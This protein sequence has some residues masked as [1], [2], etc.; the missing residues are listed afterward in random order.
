MKGVIPMCL[1]KLVIDKFG[2][3]KWKDIMKA[4]GLRED[5]IFLAHQDV[6]DSAVMTVLEQ[7][8]DV[9]GITPGQAADAFGEYWVNIFAKKVY[10]DYYKNITNA[11]DFLLNMDNVHKEA[12]ET[13]ENAHPPQFEYEEPA[14]NVLIMK[15]MSERGLVD[16]F[17]G[18][19]KGVG[20][21][22]NEELDIEKLGDNN[23]KVT[24]V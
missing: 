11:K 14:E 22:F 5:T 6:D 12:T 4:S 7:T 19:I 2:K 15:Y 18:L 24:F 8:C 17:I 16:V 21:H 20:K 23:I 3:D 9:L 1:S 13:I 10:K